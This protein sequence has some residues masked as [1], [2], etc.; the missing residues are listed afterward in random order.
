[1]KRVKLLATAMVLAVLAVMTSRVI[2]QETNT[3]ERTFMT[4]S[5]SEIGRAHV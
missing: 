4:F 3:L 5:G 2:A 1:M